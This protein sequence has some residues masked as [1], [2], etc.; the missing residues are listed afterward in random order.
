MKGISVYILPYL[1]IRCKK[2]ARENISFGFRTNAAATQISSLKNK[3]TLPEPMPVKRS[4][5]V[6][7]FED[8][9]ESSDA[10]KSYASQNKSNN[11][12]RSNK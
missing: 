12:I 9:S 7:Y 8:T 5:L 10:S 3:T 11:R 1:N 4:G 6:P 2:Y